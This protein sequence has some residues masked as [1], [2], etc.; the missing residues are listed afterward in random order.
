MKRAI[1]LFL[2]ER[3]GWIVLYYA[4]LGL[5][6][7]ILGLVF[8]FSQTGT[9]LIRQNLGYIFL[10]STSLLMIFLTIQFLRWI[11]YYRLLKEGGET[12]DSVDWF[13]VWEEGDGERKLVARAMQNL[14]RLAVAERLRFQEAERQ[15]VEFINLWVHQMK[16][17]VSTLMLM[18]QQEKEIVDN[19]RA[20][21]NGI[22]EET[23]RINEGLDMVLSMARLRDFSLDYH[24]RPVSLP[25]LV[26]DVIQEKK[27]QFI[28]LGIFPKLQVEGGEC[29]ALTDPKWN[30]FVIGQIIQ[31]ALKYTSQVKKRSYLHIQIKRDNDH[32]QLSVRDEGPGIPAHDLPRIFQPFFTGENGR[33]YLQATG[34]GLY[35]VKK[36]LDEL[37]HQ[38][39]VESRIEEGT[40]VTIIYPQT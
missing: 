9:Q 22:E 13:A 15:H 5:V 20:F 8:S 10:C 16:M 6:V 17:P 7:L 3:L 33:K 37:N 12:A 35:L 30:R 28:R 26:R 40:K 11:S 14:Y 25:D 34:M 4:N 19:P 1:V 32:I 29:T 21:L 38:I 27:K 31:N 39:Q 24:I 23:E 2:R 18:T 36:V